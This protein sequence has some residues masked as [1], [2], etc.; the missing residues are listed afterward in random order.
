MK[1]SFIALLAVAATTV[2]GHGY[3]REF[4]IG[5]T[6]HTGSLVYDD[7]TKI[8]IPDRIT[9]S[10]FPNGD[11]PITYIYYKDDLTCNRVAAPAKLVAPAPAGSQITFFWSRWFD[12]HKGPIITYLADCGGDCTK[13]NGTTL[14]WFK[15]DEAGLVD[16]T[17]ATETFMKQGN[18][19]TLTLPKKIKN[20]QYLMRH[21]IIALHQAKYP[22]GAQFY[23]SCSNIEITGGTGENTPATV[24]FPQA[25]NAKDPGILININPKPSSYIIPG[26]PLY[27][28]TAV[29]AASC[30][31]SYQECQRNVHA[32]KRNAKRTACENVNKKSCAVEFRRCNEN[33]D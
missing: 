8:P 18:S 6:R 33:L 12:D 3:V 21:E 10:F 15:I 31:D 14:N 13:A 11:S 28:E 24:Q 27:T 30:R 22:N 23:M 7:K 29:T 2:S 32:C 4:L 1:V 25:Y 17:W 5:G 20:G 19:W 9:Q 16:G 26:P